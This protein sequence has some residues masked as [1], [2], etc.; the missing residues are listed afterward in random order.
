MTYFEASG[1]VFVLGA[2]ASVFAGYPLASEL[3]GFVRD[4]QS[5][6][7]KTRDLASRVLRN[8]ATQRSTWARLPPS[9]FGLAPQQTVGSI[10][11]RYRTRVSD[12]LA[13]PVQRSTWVGIFWEGAVAL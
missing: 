7:P 3:L 8:W 9:A 11:T 2:G 6:E 1:I 4:F 12:V 13:G 5:L 10:S